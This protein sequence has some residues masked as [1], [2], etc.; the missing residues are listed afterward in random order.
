MV[1]ITVSR[2]HRPS[3]RAREH[4]RVPVKHVIYR[5]RTMLH[6]VCVA[7][8]WFRSRLKDA[9]N[10]SLTLQV[11]RWSNKHKKR[12]TTLQT[13]MCNSNKIKRVTNMLLNITF[14]KTYWQTEAILS[15]CSSIHK[16]WRCTSLHAVNVCTLEE[17]MSS[18][19][20]TKT[21]KT[22]KSNNERES[23][24]RRAKLF[25]N[26]TLLIRICLN[27]YTLTRFD[28]IWTLLRECSAGGLDAP[29][30]GSDQTND[31]AHAGDPA[32]CAHCAHGQAGTSCEA[33]TLSWA[34]RSL[35]PHAQSLVRS[36]FHVMSCSLSISPTSPH[37]LTLPG[38]PQCEP[39]G[40][41]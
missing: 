4:V 7:N 6:G 8:C 30:N 2:V 3:L 41:Q 37:I 1:H 34:R 18:R 13:S 23:S 15:A 32:A 33:G 38:W 16:L 5:P 31:W 29:S 21:D 11:Q 12:T 20:P 26:I 27:V 17:Y 19:K 9:L 10:E 40:P 36:E 28:W 22:H 35:A 14:I 24:R 25:I 39:Q